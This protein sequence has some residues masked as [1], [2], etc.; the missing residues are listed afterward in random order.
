[1]RV[2]TYVGLL[3]QDLIRRGH[4][5]PGRGP[6]PWALQHIAGATQAEFERWGDRVRDAESLTAVFEA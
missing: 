5:L 3:C 4:V 1:M 6:P 2:M